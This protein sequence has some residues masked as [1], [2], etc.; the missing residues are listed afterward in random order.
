[1]TVAERL[2][3][4]VMPDANRLRRTLAPIDRLPAP[5]R[6]WA[7]SQLVGRVVPFVG[8][9]GLRFEE[10]SPERAIVSIPNQRSVRNHIG[11]VHAAAMTLLAET[12]TGFVVGMNVPDDRV[13]VIKS[14]QVE[15]VKRSKGAMRAVAQL[16]PEDRERM[17][18]EPKGEVL[19]PVTVT[20]ESGGEPIVCKMLWAWTPKR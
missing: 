10:L 13:P 4:R 14:L 5:L 7:R 3:C 1:M 15:F 18:S 16:S 9:A 19:V 17:R 6:P 8:T 2:H 12:A 20:D 11:S